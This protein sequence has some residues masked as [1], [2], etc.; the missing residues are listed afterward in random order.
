L[1]IVRHG[2]MSL[3]SEPE[4]TILRSINISQVILLNTILPT[5]TPFISLGLHLN[6]LDLLGQIIMLGKQFIR[7][8][9]RNDIDGDV[10]GFVFEPTMNINI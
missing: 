2:Y 5:R 1:A 10:G 7:V 4:F 3:G 9:S 8:N 6:R